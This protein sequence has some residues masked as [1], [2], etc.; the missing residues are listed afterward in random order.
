MSF[1]MEFN[2]PINFNLGMIGENTYTGFTMSVSCN[3]TENKS[4]SREK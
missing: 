3:S 4:K 1:L 2:Y